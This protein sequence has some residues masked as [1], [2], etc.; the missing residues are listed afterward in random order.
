MM[1]MKKIFSTVTGMTALAAF[2]G[3][4]LLGGCNSGAQY[5]DSLA[6]VHTALAQNNLSGVQ[7]AQDRDKGVI[8]LSGTL[9]TEAQKEQAQSVT[10]EAAA[11]YRVQDDIT[12]VPPQ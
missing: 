8:T 5:P 4:L 7:V 9:P 2:S 10:M 11:T 6:A 12:V 3:A 1:A